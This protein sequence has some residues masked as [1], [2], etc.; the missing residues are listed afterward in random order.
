MDSTIEQIKKQLLDHS[1]CSK[2]Y[3]RFFKDGASLRLLGVKV[4]ILRKI[5]K[6]FKQID[7]PSISLLLRSE[8]HEEKLL[9]LFLLSGKMKK[10]EEEAFAFYLSH[11]EHVNNWDLVDA[12]AEKILGRYLINRNRDILYKLSKSSS[13]WE[14]RIAIVASWAFIRRGEF[15]DTFRLARELLSD[16]EDLIHKATGWMLREVGKRKRSLLERFLQEH[17]ASMPRTMLRYAIEHFPEPVR[18]TFLNEKK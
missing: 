4:P 1:G 13:L 17:K 15:D 6:E 16:K 7:F 10:A 18:K 8:I 3:A 9:A 11:L 2:N 5:A 12:S 14:R